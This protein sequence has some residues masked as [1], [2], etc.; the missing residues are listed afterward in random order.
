ME[1][2]QT[3]VAADSA[4]D[5]EAASTVAAAGNDFIK[6]FKIPPW[7]TVNH[8]GLPFHDYQPSAEI[9]SAVAASRCGFECA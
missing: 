9:F 2:L 8:P 7:Y 4:A 6:R 3:S 5:K 1:V